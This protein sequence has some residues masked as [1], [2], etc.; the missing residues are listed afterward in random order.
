MNEAQLRRL[1][2][3]AHLYRQG[4]SQRELAT[5]LGVSI[6]MARAFLIV[7]QVPLRSTTDAVAL[8]N[9]RRA[10]GRIVNVRLFDDEGR[11]F[12]RKQPETVRN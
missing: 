5:A 10:E 9:A 7:A 4:W 1:R 11:P 3:A 12:T 2:S 8:A 6:E